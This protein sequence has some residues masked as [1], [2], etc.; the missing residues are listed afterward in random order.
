MA[1][2]TDTRRGVMVLGTIA[3]VTGLVIAAGAMGFA[4]WYGRPIDTSALQHED[5]LVWPRH[6]FASLL[7]GAASAVAALAVLGPVVAAVAL[8][9]SRSG[10]PT[11]DPAPD[12]AGS[13][14][15]AGLLPG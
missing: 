7:A 14:L 5:P 8:R 4:W 1:T 15:G 13:R 9:R 2:T 12:V 10:I 3:L 6:L 11:P